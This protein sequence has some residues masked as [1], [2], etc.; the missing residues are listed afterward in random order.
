M[1][2]SCDT[3]D[4][5]RLDSGSGWERS[6]LEIVAD[7]GFP[8]EG[9]GALRIYGT[10]PA[11]RE[12][13]SYLSVRVSIP[14]TDFRGQALV[15][16]AATSTPAESE[17]LYV[18]GYDAEGGCVL[19]WT[20]WNGQLQ[21]E[22]QTFAL[23]PRIPSGGIAWEPGVIKSDDHSAVTSLV[24]TSANLPMPE[25]LTCSWTTSAPRSPRRSR[26]RERAGAP[27]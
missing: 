13:N 6:G 11:D 4:G 25:E 22:K 17:A 16:D 20:S 10:S 9:A 26:G 14:A 7:P 15:F 23:H 2:H 5:L 3:L 24:S 21:A 12:G 1:L 27:S 19:S 18:R 8:V